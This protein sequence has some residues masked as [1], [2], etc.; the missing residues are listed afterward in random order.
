M[1]SGDGAAAT[2]APDVPCRV[3]YPPL[4]QVLAFFEEHSAAALSQHVG[5][6]TT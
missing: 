3:G 1:A 4:V 2:A 5:H 6:E